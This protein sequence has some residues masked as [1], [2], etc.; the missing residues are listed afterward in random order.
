MGDRTQRMKRSLLIIEPDLLT[1]WSLKTYLEPWFTIYVGSA[2]DQVR[3]VAS[4]KTL[5]AM[6]VSDAVPGV[7]AQ[8]IEQTARDRNPAIQIV[9]TVSGPAVVENSTTDTT[10]RLEKP[11]ELQRLK[12]LLGVS[13]PNDDAA[14]A[15]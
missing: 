9:H 5:D 15:H 7:T 4:E 3:K 13:N 14:T 8:Q 2:P 10:Y 1:R 6:I 11:F 12:L